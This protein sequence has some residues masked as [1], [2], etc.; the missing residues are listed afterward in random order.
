MLL[1]HSNCVTL[2]YRFQFSFR[3]NIKDNNNNNNNN[4]IEVHQ[5][6][7]SKNSTRLMEAV[8]FNTNREFHS[9]VG[10]KQK[11]IAPLHCLL[12]VTG[13]EHVVHTRLTH[14]D[15]FREPD[16]NLPSPS[17]SCAR[18]SSTMSPVGKPPYST[19]PLPTQATAI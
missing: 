9:R 18:E 5:Q 10:R 3:K 6:A 4:S 15:S 7:K 2:Q 16:P 12:R 17:T 11:L 1:P 19:Q 13:V 8:I 14:S